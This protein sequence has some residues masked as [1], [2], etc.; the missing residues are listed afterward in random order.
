MSPQHMLE[1]NRLHRDAVRGRSGTIARSCSSRRPPSASVS[2]PSGRRRKAQP[3][4][5]TPQLGNGPSPGPGARLSLS[6]Y[7]HVNVLN[8]S[9]DRMHL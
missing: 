8:S 2:P 6:D 9:Y 1:P 3:S 7:I 5:Q 4:A